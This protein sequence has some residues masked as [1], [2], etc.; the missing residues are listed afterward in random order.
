MFKN[1][2]KIGIN[3]ISSEQLTN[4]NLNDNKYTISDGYHP[5]EKAWELLSKPLVQKIENL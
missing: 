4:E 3:V 1:L 2:Q 5:N